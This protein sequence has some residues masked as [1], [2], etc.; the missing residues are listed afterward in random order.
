MVMT[1]RDSVS[2]YKTEINDD[3][4]LTSFSSFDSKGAKSEILQNG[5]V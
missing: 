4:N 5:F 1:L 3:N 2:H